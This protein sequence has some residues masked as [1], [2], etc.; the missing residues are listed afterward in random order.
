MSEA[1]GE[2]RHRGHRNSV[3]IGELSEV[4]AG[5]QFDGSTPQ[6]VWT[7]E[8]PS[9]SSGVGPLP[10]MSCPRRTKTRSQATVEGF[11]LPLDLSGCIDWLSVLVVGNFSRSYRFYADN[12]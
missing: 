12:H 5:F 4:V 7:D 6:G 2:G 11:F 3:G 8:V 10:M 1:P 9:I